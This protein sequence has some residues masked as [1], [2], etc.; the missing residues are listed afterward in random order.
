MEKKEEV[1]NVRVSQ[2]AIN[3]VREGLKPEVLK[4]SEAIKTIKLAYNNYI[5]KNY[6]AAL[7]YFQKDA[8]TSIK[9]SLDVSK[10]IVPLV[11]NA[12]KEYESE[13]IKIDYREKSA[14][15]QEACKVKEFSELLDLYHR[16][17]KQYENTYPNAYQNSK[18]IVNEHQNRK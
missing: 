9:S 1:K 5:D 8:S 17:K 18:A 16:L 11:S 15:I 2:G 6:E 12:L 3:Q 14:K 10:I 7:S 4:V 13:E